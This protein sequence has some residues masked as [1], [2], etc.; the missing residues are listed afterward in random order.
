VDPK[1]VVLEQVLPA[2]E[3]LGPLSFAW[4]QG[5][6]VNG[7]TTEGDYDVIL[8]W[9]MESLPTERSAVRHGCRHRSHLLRRKSRRR[10]ARHTPR[11]RRC[12]LCLST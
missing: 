1:R 11:L 10:E 12:L 5:S 6:L 4:A 9:D 7:F 3:T 2:Y 8:A